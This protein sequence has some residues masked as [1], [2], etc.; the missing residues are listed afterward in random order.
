MTSSRSVKTLHNPPMLHFEHEDPFIGN[1]SENQL[2]SPERPNLFN[3]DSS[4]ETNSRSSLPI[5]KRPKLGG[6]LLPVVGQN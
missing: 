3:N 1:E 5:V 6:N 2:N 4:E